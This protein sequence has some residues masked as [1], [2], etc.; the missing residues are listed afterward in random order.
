MCPN[1]C[2]NELT[3]KGKKKDLDK[4]KSKLKDKLDFNDFIPYPENFRMLDEKARKHEEKTGNWIKDGYNS[5]GY[6]WC[7][8]NWGTKW[9]ASNCEVTKDEKKVLFRFD[10]AWSPPIPV[11]IAMSKKFPKLR[12]NLRY[13]EGGMGVKGSLTLKNGKCIN[14]QQS[15]Y[16]GH[17]GG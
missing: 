5:G 2:E 6:Q 11:I 17:R 3:I 12:F 8:E 10:T 13:W 9:N 16:S 1:W 7:C 14:N 15:V 4:F